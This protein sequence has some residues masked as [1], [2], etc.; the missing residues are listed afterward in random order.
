VHLRAR[1]RPADQGS[2]ERV[3]GHE[4]TLGRAASA[5]SQD[6]GLTNRYPTPVSVSR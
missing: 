6:F 4:P 5:S 3:G 2:L 1:A